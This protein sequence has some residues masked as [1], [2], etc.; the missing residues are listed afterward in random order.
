MVNN[1]QVEVKAEKQT[2]PSFCPICEEVIREAMEKNPG[3]EAIYCE[4]NV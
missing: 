3:D 4:G 2:K 1:V